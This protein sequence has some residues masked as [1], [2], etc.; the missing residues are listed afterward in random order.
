V[1]RTLAFR[2]TLA[3]ALAGAV[4]LFSPVVSGAAGPVPPVDVRDFH[5][6]DGTPDGNILTINPGDSVSWHVVNGTHTV[7]PDDPAL[8]FFHDSGTL[9]GGEDYG[10]VVFN[11]LGDYPYHCTFHRDSDGMTGVVKVVEPPP[12][13]TSST[14]TTTAPPATTTTTRPSTTTTTGHGP[15]TTTTLPPT[16]TTTAARPGTTTTTPPTVA[17]A[18]PAL[19]SPTTA[20][21]PAPTTTTAKSK[22]KKAAGPTTTTGKKGKGGGKSDQGTGQPPAAPVDGTSPEVTGGDLPALES[23]DEG[24]ASGS[25]PAAEGAAE[26]AAPIA[27]HDKPGGRHGTGLLLGTGVIVTLL[28][29]GALVYKW[30]TRDS[31][32][33]TA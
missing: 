32:Y 18:G 28:G 13:T 5:F 33:W 7:T 12:T 9:T 6:G 1:L 26:Q 23:G 3:A 14:T 20:G 22:D 21:P 31:A 4:T 15:T 17:A 30:R 2:L 10:P 29:L 16:T 19:T 24:A 27:E 11:T 25:D 8:D